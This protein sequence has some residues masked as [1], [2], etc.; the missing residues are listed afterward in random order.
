MS[1][2]L[3]PAADSNPYA[4]EANP[5]LQRHHWQALASEV[6]DFRP[7]WPIS[8]I[9]NTLWRCRGRASFPELTKTALTVAMSPK[10]KTPG[11][12]DLVLSGLIA[13]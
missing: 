11:A 10:C 2:T 5:N 9:I 7:E 12:L 6:N 3:A 13:L 8:E 1:T 4:T